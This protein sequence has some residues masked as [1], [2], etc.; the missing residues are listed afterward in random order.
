[1]RKYQKLI[2]FLKRYTIVHVLVYLIVGLVFMYI[3]NYRDA[4]E[5]YD[6]F[7]NYRSLDS[8]IVRAAVFF[9]LLR[10]LMI[11]LIIY[12]FREIIIE[13]QLGWLM[14]FSLLFGL[15]CLGAINASPGSI[16]GMI[17]TKM[18]LEEHLVGYPEV[19][20]QSL[21]ISIIFWKWEKKSYQ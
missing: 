16:E 5:T 18:S 14:L 21:G 1:M 8:P 3:M 6:Q 15:T 7:S 4:F 11:G 12:P 2:G 17:Y 10:G 9:Q 13:S 20:V 19:I